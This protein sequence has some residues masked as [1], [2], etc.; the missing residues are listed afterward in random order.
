MLTAKEKQDR[1]IASYSNFELV[2]QVADYKDQALTKQRDEDSLRYWL[3][4][5]H[6]LPE[7]H[8]LTLNDMVIATVQDLLKEVGKRQLTIDRAKN[9][10]RFWKRFK[11]R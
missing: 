1:R 5:N 3:D 8:L 10:K 9:K 6:P 7:T 4:Q 2:R 11:R